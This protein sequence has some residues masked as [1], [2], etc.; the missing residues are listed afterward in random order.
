MHLPSEQSVKEVLRTAQAT[1]LDVEH[2]NKLD[3]VRRFKAILRS[4]VRKLERPA[5]HVVEYPADPRLMENWQDMYGQD[6]PCGKSSGLHERSGKYD[7]PL[8]RTKKSSASTEVATQQN[9]NAKLMA[10][11]M[12]LMPLMPL[13]GN[14][15]QGEVPLQ[16]LQVFGSARSGT[17][18]RPKHV[19]ALP[20]PEPEAGATAASGLVRFSDKAGVSLQPAE[21]IP[22]GN[23][24]P[25]LRRSNAAILDAESDSEMNHD[26][27]K[28]SKDFLAAKQ[29]RPLKRPAA[30]LSKKP[31]AAAPGQTSFV[32]NVPEPDKAWRAKRRD[33]WT[34]KHY[35]SARQQA[36]AAGL[37]DEECAEIA[38]RAGRE[39]GALWDAA[40]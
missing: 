20:A 32:Y 13:L 40:Q 2:F 34:S 4:K 10:A 27:E 5:K 37:P 7:V 31:A 28:E 3:V 19:P 17:S 38:R 6:L 14:M 22:S 26:P 18:P 15:M 24:V 36:R 16:N 30:A 33:N 12:P 39:A 23:E 25:K 11:L 8:R 35:H 21:P 9:A 29:K 1:G